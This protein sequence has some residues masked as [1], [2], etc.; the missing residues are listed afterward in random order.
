MPDTSAHSRSVG[1]DRA[2]RFVVA[3]RRATILELEDLSFPTG[4]SIF[5]P[6]Y[7]IDPEVAEA[8]QRVT[9]LA[10]VAATLA[11]ARRFPDK[12]LWIAGHTDTQG[13]HAVNDAL[14]RDRA[15]NVRLFLNADSEAWADHC[16]QVYQVDDYQ[17]VLAWVHRVH[18]WDV[19]PGPIDNQF[20]DQTREARDRFRARYNEEYGGSL[21][22]GVK[23]NPADWQ[24]YATLYEVTLG[25]ILN[26]TLETVGELRASLRFTQPEF[27]G[28]GERFPRDRSDVDHLENAANRRVELVFFDPGEVPDLEASPAGSELY[29]SRVHHREYLHVDPFFHGGANYRV[30][31]RLTDHWLDVVLTDR[32]YRLTGPLPNEPIE[33][34][35]TTDEDGVLHES[36]LPS[37]HYT[38]EVLPIEGSEGG[39]AM[40]LTAYQDPTPG[41]AE[42][43]TAVPMSGVHHARGP[44][45]G[46]TGPTDP[47]EWNVPSYSVDDRELGTAL[48]PEEDHDYD[49]DDDFDDDE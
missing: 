20:G 27:T 13:S 42:L 16:N 4:R 3:R 24:A 46:L 31:A 41:R 5:V 18:G 48:E 6:D 45:L 38:V 29:Q 15:E 23:Q 10:V 17:R 30:L 32:E 8:D 12:D 1:L 49:E 2:H 33:R 34:R 37:G 25:H 14:S 22:R 40:L 47:Y 44:H 9:G 21:E 26:E 39:R 35:G 36:E 43:P 7:T 11:F 28:C 19:D